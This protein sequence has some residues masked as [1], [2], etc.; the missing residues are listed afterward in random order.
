MLYRIVSWQHYTSGFIFTSHQLNKRNGT[1]NLLIIFLL[2]HLF[3]L[4]GLIHVS[5]ASTV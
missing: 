4:R 1:M 3:V 2:K 5:T